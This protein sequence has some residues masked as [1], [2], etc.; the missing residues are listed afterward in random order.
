[1]SED[2]LIK[3]NL[4]KILPKTILNTMKELNQ[5][6]SLDKLWRSILIQE[7]KILNMQNIIYIENKE[8]VT[9]V[10]KKTSSGNVS[11]K[12]YEIQFAWDKENSAMSAL[13]KAM[14]VLSDMI[15]QY[16]ELVHKNW[17]LVTEEQKLRIEKLKKEVNSMEKEDK[18]PMV[19]F[20][21]EDDLED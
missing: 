21:G 20:G 6:S 14:K 18:K 9:K 16:E 11:S 12:E 3:G 2:R 4:D 5:E 15:K 8:D 17:N 13:S 19:I 10:L 1:M 7:S